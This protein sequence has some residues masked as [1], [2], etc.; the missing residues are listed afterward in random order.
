MAILRFNG[1]DI[2]PEPS[3]MNISIA[4]LSSDDS[5]RTSRSGSLN[6]I[7]IARKRTIHLSWNN[8]TQAEAKT[9]LT[10]LRSGTDPT[11]VSVT[12]DGDPE[13]SYAVTKVF[14]YGDISVAFQQVWVSGRK[15]Y[16]HLTFDLIEK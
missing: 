14:A 1:T 4:D 3:E 9:I 10:N 16:S 11:F 7:V 15:R 8:I 12:Y 13:Y 5:G 2:T 6:K